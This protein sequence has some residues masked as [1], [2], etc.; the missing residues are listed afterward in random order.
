MDDQRNGLLS[1]CRW[2]TTVAAP[3]V[4]FSSCESEVTV[5]IEV[6]TSPLSSWLILISKYV[7]HLRSTRLGQALA[8]NGIK[9]CSCSSASLRPPDLVWASSCTRTRV[10]RNKCFAKHEWDRRRPSL[11]LLPYAFLEEQ[12][13]D[14]TPSTVL[15]LLTLLSSATPELEMY[16]ALSKVTLP[17]AAPTSAGTASV[18]EAGPQVII[19]S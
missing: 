9:A 12:Y 18:I 3:D 7:P 6:P 15:E 13:S 2:C 16:H 17:A 19:G 10:H 4:M 1:A 11:W 5:P 14:A 8:D